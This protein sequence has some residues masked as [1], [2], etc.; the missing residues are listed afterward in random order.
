MHPWQQHTLAL[1]KKERNADDKM[2]KKEPTTAKNV[3]NS[4]IELLR[5]LITL[6]VII[7]HYNNKNNGKAFVYAEALPEQYQILVILEMVAICAVNVFVLISGYFMCNSQKADITKV[8]RLYLDVMLLAAIKYLLNCVLNTATFSCAKLL[9][10]MI[11]L[12]W[13]VA[14]YSGLYLLSPYLNRTIR[15]LSKPQFRTMLLVFLTVCSIWPSALELTTALTGTKLT[16]MCPLGTQGSGA[17]YTLIHFIMMYFLGA[18][19]RLHP[20][21]NHKSDWIPAFATYIGCTILLVLYSKVYWSGAV[22]Y[23]NPLVILQAAALFQI[24]QSFQFKSRWINEIS[25]CSFGVY[26]L[27]STF[28][29]YFPIQIHATGTPWMIPFHVGWTAIKIYVICA[30]IYWIYQNVLGRLLSKILKK[31]QFMQYEVS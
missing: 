9:R 19:F 26:L 4:N 22:S 8:I 11:P 20:G 15:G 12:S 7:V 17:G 25:G 1:I 3:R 24:F 29:R 10:T 14:V 27:H 6:F 16:S 21:K 13:Y 2:V 5:I 28:F 18:Y 30:V 31:L 23:C